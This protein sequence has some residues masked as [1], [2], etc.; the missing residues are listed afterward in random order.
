MRSTLDVGMGLMNG[1]GSPCGLWVIHRVCGGELIDGHPE[2]GE[3]RRVQ[4]G[5]FQLPG[6]HPGAVVLLKRF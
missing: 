4:R 5:E 2:S 3:I 1:L 6:G